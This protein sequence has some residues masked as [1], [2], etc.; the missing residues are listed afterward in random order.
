[1]VLENLLVERRRDASEKAQVTLNVVAQVSA[2]EAIP[3]LKVGE[4]AI[5]IADRVVSLRERQNASVI[6]SSPAAAVAAN[7]FSISW[8]SR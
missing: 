4:R 8:R 1:M 7:I 6:L 3:D 5:V 2:P